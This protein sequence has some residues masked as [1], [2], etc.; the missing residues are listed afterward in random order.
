MISKYYLFLR[1]ENKKLFK[2][3]I[4]ILM[5]TF[6]AFSLVACKKNEEEDFLSDRISVLIKSK[7]RSEFE[8]KE[9]TIESFDWNN[10]KSI[11]YEIWYEDTNTGWMVVYLKEHGKKNVIDAINHFNSLEFVKVAEKVGVIAV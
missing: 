11:S 8:A 4:V 10:I 6:M 5:I 9:I 7:Y 3:I 1:M 2:K